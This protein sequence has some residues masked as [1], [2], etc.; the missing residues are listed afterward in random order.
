MEEDIP[1]LDLPEDFIAGDYITGAILYQ[2]GRFPCKIK[3]GLFVLCMQ[4]SVRATINL[5]EYIIGQHDFVTLLPNSFIQIHDVSGDAKLYF[6]GFS[7][8]FMSRVNFIKSTMNFLPVITE[9]P[10]MKLPDLVAKL[11]QE[12]Y[13]LVIH[14]YSLPNT[15]QN[16][17]IIKSILA[18]FSQGA[19][20]LYKNHTQWISP[21]RTR[22]NEIYREFMQLVM[23]HYTTEHSV[24][25]YAQ[26]MGLTLSHFCTCIKKATGRTPLEIITAI[27]VMDAKA[28]LK[29]T[30]LPVKSIAFTLGFNNLSFFNKFFRQHV[31]MT[32]QEYRAS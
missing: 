11:Y 25:F 27:L 1:K 32:P 13:Q 29:S 10:V 21:S 31:H 6:A 26:K 30:D 23:E 24:T 5:T 4:G 19:A 2:Y 3:A 9:H 16:K 18:I 7:S 28:Q 12:A 8:G 15:L 14:A 20:E 22:D 17:E